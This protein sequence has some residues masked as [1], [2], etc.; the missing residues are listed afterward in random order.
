[1]IS[2]QHTTSL[3]IQKTQKFSSILVCF[4]FQKTLFTTATALASPSRTWNKTGAKFGS[5]APRG[6]RRPALGREN[7]RRNEEK[8]SLESGADI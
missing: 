5:D 3:Q 7:R 2:C 4:N 6:E 1:M 8:F